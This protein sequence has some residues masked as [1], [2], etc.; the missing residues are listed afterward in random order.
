VL[1]SREKRPLPGFAVLARF[2]RYD[3]DRD[4]KKERKLRKH[5]ALL[6][7]IS[8]TV[9]LSCLAPAVSLAQSST[10]TLLD[11]PADLSPDSPPE[12]RPPSNLMTSR[13]FQLSLL[14]LV[15]GVVIV[16]IQYLLLRGVIRQKT[17]IISR[18]Y[19]VTLIIVGTMFLIT[20]GYNNDQISPAIALFGTI[21]GYL[22]GRI[23]QQANPKPEEEGK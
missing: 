2:L 5:L 11:V 18:S 16:V 20:A 1:R 17:E 15:F 4:R 23:D 3:L 21:A 12:R 9:F 13:E 10:P 22:L 7:I 6:V 8:S 14:I 19:T